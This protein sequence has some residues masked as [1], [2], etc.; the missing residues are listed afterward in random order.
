M[1]SASDITCLVDGH[2]VLLA[3]VLQE[4]FGICP[5][6]TVFVRPQYQHL[7]PLPLARQRLQ[8]NS[9]PCPP[10]PS[11]KRLDWWNYGEASLFL[12]DGSI[13]RLPA[14]LCCPKFGVSLRGRAGLKGGQFLDHPTKAVHLPSLRTLHIN[15]ATFS[16]LRSISNWFLPAL[17]TLIMDVALRLSLVWAAHG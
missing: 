13:I 15:V 7:P 14:V 9:T 6:I 2:R 12:L 8:F 16:L 17:N 11:L 3:H 10:L 1:G 4:V 5:N